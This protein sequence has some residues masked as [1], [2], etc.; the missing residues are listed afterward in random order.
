MFEAHRDHFANDDSDVLV[1]HAATRLMNPTISEDYIQKELAKDPEAARA[2]WLAE[3]RKDL[4]SFLPLE[5][6]ERATV[7]GR[8]KLPPLCSFTYQAFCDPSG[9]AGDAFTLS[10]GHKDGGRLIQDVLRSKRSPFNPHEV[11]KE[12]AA[13]LK[14]Y[15]IQ[16]IKGDYYAA[17]WTSMAFQAEGITYQ[18]SKKTKSELYL[19]F[20]PLLAQGRV[21]MLDNKTLFNELRSLERRTG[22]SGKDLIN[23]GPRQHDDS[24]NATAGLMV[25]L[26]QPGSTFRYFF[27]DLDQCESEKTKVPHTSY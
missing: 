3:F 6:V 15:R 17:E 11:V 10:I 18:R 13:L 8:Y 22:R 23:H 4:E 14:Q 24:A 19:E 12:Y 26:A 16:S 9:G 20:E 5:W 1:W 25:N 7:P 2:E 27:L 21:E